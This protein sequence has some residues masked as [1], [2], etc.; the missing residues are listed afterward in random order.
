[1]AGSCKKAD[2]INLSF[3]LSI[4]KLNPFCSVINCKSQKAIEKKYLFI[5]IVGVFNYEDS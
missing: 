2:K 4:G 1:V 3:K 5:K